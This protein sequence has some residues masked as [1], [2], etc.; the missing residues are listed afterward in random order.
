MDNLLLADDLELFAMQDDLQSLG[1][2]PSLIMAAATIRSQ[3]RE[4]MALKEELE[5][6]RGDSSMKKPSNPFN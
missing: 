4:I 2:S 1:V 6:A 5:T 3:A